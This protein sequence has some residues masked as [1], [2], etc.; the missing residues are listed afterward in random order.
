MGRAMKIWTFGKRHSY[1]K[2]SPTHWAFLR[3]PFLRV[4]RL[5]ASLAIAFFLLCAF[6]SV[7]SAQIVMDGSMSDPEWHKLGDSTG[8]PPTSSAGNE[9]NA[10]YAEIDANYFYI[11]VAGNVQPGSRILV[12]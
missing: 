8:G 12:F 10:L 11:G 6:S 7:A 5:A 3:V 9:I 4:H 1:L 2:G